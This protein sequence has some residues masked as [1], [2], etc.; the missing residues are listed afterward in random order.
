MKIL[1]SLSY[2]LV[3]ML[4]IT[5]LYFSTAFLLANFPKQGS[6]TQQDQTLYLLY[7][8]MHSDIILDLTTAGYPWRKLLPNIRQYPHRGYLG[9]GWGD[10]GTY[11]S[12]PTWDKLTPSIA[13]KA[14]FLNTDSLIH[15]NYYPRIKNFRNSIAIKVNNAQYH[16]IEKLILRSFGEQPHFV[17]RGYWRRDAFYD[18][19][20]QYNL[21]KTCNTWTGDILREAN[22]TMSY[23][24]PLS[25]NVVRSLKDII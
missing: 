21:F 1:K 20:Y 6:C 13:F 9:F 4:L 5:L 3:G 7:D 18:S 19:P 17:R 22:I 25:D 10:K 15:V 14:L 11:L 2:L 12:T 8:E 16:T 23:W 24:T